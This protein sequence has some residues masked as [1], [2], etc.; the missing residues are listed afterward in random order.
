MDES[1]TILSTVKK[2]LN[3]DDNTT[4]FDADIKAYVNGAFFSLHQLGIGPS[5][6]FSIDDTTTWGDYT[7]SVPKS[8]VLD[9]LHLKTA[10]IFDPP[11][12][13]SVV[14]AYKDRISELEFRMNI[15]VDN[16]GGDVT[17]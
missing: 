12:S 3:I 1:S 10:I 14:E 16:G 7:T 11:S 15:L 9:Y 2:L 6:P 13:S 4:E 17:G 8:V 5:V